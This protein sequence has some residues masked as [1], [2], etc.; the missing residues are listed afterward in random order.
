MRPGATAALLLSVATMT[1]AGQKET[2]MQ[3]SGSFEVTVTPGHGGDG[4][5]GRMMLS[6][7]YHGGLDA[8]AVG[9]MLTGGDLKAGSAGYVAIETVTGSLEGKTGTFQ[10]M[11]WGTMADGKLELRVGVV[12]GSGTGALAG[13]SGTMTI[14]IAAGGKHTYRLNYALA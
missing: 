8:A 1:S 6:K 2:K 9:E 10:L 13:I 7:H 11:Q 12:P 14:E 4:G 3:A 5:Y